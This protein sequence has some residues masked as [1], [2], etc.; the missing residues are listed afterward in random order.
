MVNDMG[1]IQN[2]ILNEEKQNSIL[3]YSKIQPCGKKHRKD[4][5]R[6]GNTD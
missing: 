2:R 4:L 3:F 6:N 1:K 5:Q